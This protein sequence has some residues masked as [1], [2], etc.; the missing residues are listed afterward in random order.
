MRQKA[1]VEQV[2]GKTVHRF[3]RIYLA[4]NCTWSFVD[5]I[6]FKIIVL[7]WIQWFWILILL[8]DVSF[9]R[10]R[11]ID[12][13]LFLQS[14]KL[15]GVVVVAWVLL[16]KGGGLTHWAFYSFVKDIHW[17]L[18]VAFGHHW[19]RD[20]AGGTSGRFTQSLLAIKSCVLLIL[21]QLFRILQ[22]FPL[23]IN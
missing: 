22:V 21:Q 8:G 10:H 14:Q 5:T 23:G 3:A 19:R 7:G 2:R 18:F 11:S 6:F 13:S 9:R 20:T 15:E 12:V 16:C 1:L 17:L 4:M